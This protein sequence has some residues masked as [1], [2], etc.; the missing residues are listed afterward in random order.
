MDQIP[1]SRIFKSFTLAK[2]AAAPAAAA[3]AADPL[4]INKQVSRQANVFHP[5]HNPLTE[6]YPPTPSPSPEPARVPVERFPRPVPKIQ[7]KMSQKPQNTVATGMISPKI[8]VESSKQ[9]AIAAKKEPSDSITSGIDY[10]KLA[11]SLT[12]RAKEKVA[13]KTDYSLIGYGMLAVAA[14]LALSQ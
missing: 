7:S 9:R 4:S 14:I 13:Q 3:P 2:P 1:S 5:T 11:K 12:S 6:E 8:Y 10:D